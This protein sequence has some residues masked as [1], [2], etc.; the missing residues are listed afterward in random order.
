MNKSV[1]IVVT[2]NRKKLLVKNIEA[3]LNQSIKNFDILIIDNASNDGTFE[4]I[5]KYLKNFRVKY[6]NTGKN[7]GGAG[8]FEYGLCNAIEMQYEKFWLMDDDTIPEKTAYEELKAADEV[9]KEEYGFLSSIVLWK[10]DTYCLMNKQKIKKP[11]YQKGKYL[12]EGLL[13][14]YYATFVSF[15]LTKK[16]IEENGFPIKE[17]FIWGD[18]VEYSTRIAKRKDCYIA[19]KSVVRHETAMN[20][21]SSIEKDSEDRIARYF[22]AYRNE[23][24][25]AKRDGIKGVTYQILKLFYHLLKI[26]FSKNNLK[27]KKIYILFKGTINGIFFNPKVKYLKI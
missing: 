9:L 6:L 4:E 5:D 15:F 13:P 1:A 10:D 16:V 17:F 21:G 20:K 19:L 23:M 7:L 26:I 18:D 8:G 2:Y 27:L 12:K 3:L 11:W 25:I 14:T 22:Y 24:Y